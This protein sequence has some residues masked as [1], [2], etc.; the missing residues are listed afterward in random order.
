MTEDAIPLRAAAPVRR[1]EVGY[2]DDPFAA[3]YRDSFDR[4]WRLAFL[5]VGDRHVAEEV[6]QD[7]FA[8]VLER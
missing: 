5:L 7:A 8:R 2:A 4:M 3:L 6:V 1:V